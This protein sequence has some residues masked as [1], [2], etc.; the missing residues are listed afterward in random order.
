MGS[1]WSAQW[2]HFMSMYSLIPSSLLIP[3]IGIK[4]TLFGQTKVITDVSKYAL[5][6]IHL[7]A[8]IEYVHQVA[9]GQKC[10]SEIESFVKIETL[11]LD[12]A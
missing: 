6:N 11:I 7:L 9:R 2:I 4:H 1:V 3:V 12:F 10:R 8:P 5:Q